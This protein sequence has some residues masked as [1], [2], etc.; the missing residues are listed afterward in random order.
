MRAALAIFVSLFGIL[1]PLQSGARQLPPEVSS[2]PSSAVPED[3]SGGGE[4]ELACWFRRGLDLQSQADGARE[5]PE[6]MAILL[7]KAALAYEKA[8]AFDPERGP[9]LNNLAQVYADLSRDTEAERLF[10]RAV[11]PK[12]RLRPFFRRNF[13]DFLVR[14]GDWQRAAENY[15]Q[16]LEEK[17]EDLPAHTRLVEILSQHNPEALPKYLRFLIYKG[18]ILQA[19]DEALNR[20]KMENA[21]PDQ[22]EEYL[23]ILIAALAEQSY[24]PEEFLSSPTAR[25]LRSLSDQPGVGE[26]AREALR[27]HE[28]QDFHAESYLWWAEKPLAR[29]EFR[30][31]LRSLAEA[32]RKAK[33]YDAARSFLRLSMLLTQVEPDLVAFR[34]FVNLPTASEDVAEIDR[35]AETNEKL[36]PAM[37]LRR[38]NRSTPADL[39]LYRHDLGLFYGFLKHWK[40]EGPASGIYQ[41]SQAIHLGGVGPPGGP[42]DTPTFD[43]RVYTRLATGY[44]ETHNLENARLTLNQLVDA[45]R[46]QGMGAE[47]D[48]L[49]AVLNSA[50]RPHRPPDPRREF[51]DDPPFRLDDFSTQPPG[52]PQ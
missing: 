2:V 27:L 40:G 42:P 1:L 26:G 20:L 41:L 16:T 49:Q 30:H 33:R 19:E 36:L 37:D 7:N 43:A 17:P 18:R 35:M 12:A 9:I 25:V 45:F 11:T 8:L 23:T 38:N 5:Q 48:A 31:L 21:P 51:L 13:G 28:E 50:Q 44:S 10:E 15:R 52:P 14:R 47:A 6:S 29:Q 34:M 46:S 32:Q 22:G 39:S 3:C 24:L 4:E